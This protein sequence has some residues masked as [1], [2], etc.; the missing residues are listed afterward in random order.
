M[1]TLL[2]LCV[3]MRFIIIAALLVVFAMWFYLPDKEQ[4]DAVA[5]YT[6]V[7]VHKDGEQLKIV[8]VINDSKAPLKEIPVYLQNALIA[9]EDRHF[10]IHPGIDI[11]GIARAIK[12]GQGGGTITQ[13]LAKNM[14][15]SSERSYWRKAKEAVLALKLEWYYDKD[16][17]LEMYLNQIPF[18][19]GIYGIGKAAMKYFNKHARNLNLYEAALL[20]GSIPQPERFNIVKNKKL[21]HKRAHLVF[22]IMVELAYITEAEQKQAKRRGIKKGSQKVVKC[23]VSVSFGL[24]E[25]QSATF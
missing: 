3:K 8:A 22:K 5:Q 9:S 20:I 15:L 17:I 21:A 13:Q 12:N 11:M 18:G 2:I 6:R 24:G 19:R 10:Y 7:I 1:K 25:S 23:G 14:L 16:E 4:I